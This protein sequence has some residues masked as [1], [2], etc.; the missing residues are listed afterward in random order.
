MLQS[1]VSNLRHPRPR[2]FAAFQEWFSGGS[3]GKA[4]ILNG[5]AATMLDDTQDLVALRTPA[6]EDAL[7]RALQDHWPFPVD[8]AS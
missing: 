6:D 8:T 7:S 5:R 1:S 3:Q 2:V 4:A